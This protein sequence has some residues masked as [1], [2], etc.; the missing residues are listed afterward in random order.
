M[1]YP[2]KKIIV[3]RFHEENGFYTTEAR[4]KMMAKIRSRNTKPEILFRKILWHAGI[5]YRIHGK[6]L[7]GSPDIV[8]RKHKFAVFI[9]GDFW[10]GN[11]WETN[12][13]RIK[14]NSEF[15]IA[16]IERN[17]QRDRENNLKL[18]QLGFKVFRFWETD[19][20][21]QPEKCLLEITDWLAAQ[22]SSK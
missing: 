4:S 10:H 5:R 20:K 12:K 15:W 11:D 2:E 3:P 14:T 7:P 9:D 22:N 8:N 17:R 1:D 21:K 18:E 13:H 16:K 19:V 6:G